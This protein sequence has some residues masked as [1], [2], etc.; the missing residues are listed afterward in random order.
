MILIE[1][2]KDYFNKTEL[3]RINFQKLKNEKDIISAIYEQL[4]SKEKKKKYGQF[5]T[6]REVVDFILNNIPIKKTDTILDPAC[7]AG[8][9]L[10]KASEKVTNTNIYGI[11]LD[12]KALG[13]CKINLENIKINSR[14]FSNL[15]LADTLKSN[16]IDIF[17]KI[18]KKNGFD[19]IVGNPPF[20]N[21]SINSYEKNHPIYK[22][23]IN[24]IANTATLMIAKSYEFLKE[25]GYLGFVLPKSVLRVDSFRSLRY[26]LLRKTK[27]LHIYDLGHY[28]KDVRGDQIIIILQKK[29]LTEKEQL[30]SKV[31]IMILKKKNSFNHPYSYELSQS[32]F[33]RYNFFPI[34]YDKKT[35]PLINKLLKEPNNL[36]KLCNGN[37]FRGLGISTK[38]D[39]ISKEYIKNSTVIYRGDSIKRFGIKYKLFVKNL[40]STQIRKEEI[41]RLQKDKIIIQNICSKEGGIF[42]AISKNTE[43][44]LD[45]VTNIITDKVSNKYLLGILNSKL[46][47]FFLISVIFLNS[48][49]T[50]HTD[51]Q[52]IG[53][54]PIRIPK[55]EQEK[56]IVSIVDKLIELKDI[57]SKGYFEYYDKLNDEVFKIYNLKPQEIY[58]INEFLLE[59]MSKKQNGITNE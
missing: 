8:A 14:K 31:K 41:S 51:K 19:V 7:G 21:I 29:Q 40:N 4:S 22:E 46:S 6:H 59:V 5:F 45:T 32:S 9:F 16:L 57:Y 53:K 54:I 48:N 3:N 56:R 30:Q 55:K 34:F 50:M 10:I 28:F 38:S 43:L 42:A 24:G 52:Y 20:Q 11:D 17:P 37:I 13:L 25:E 44:T 26:F 18:S 12:M 36:E 27:I 39:T 2:L 35:I 49:F 15:V 58:I 47:N 33:N 1:I 23:V